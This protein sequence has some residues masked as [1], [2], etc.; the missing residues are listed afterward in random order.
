VTSTSSDYL[1]ALYPGD[2]TSELP[3]RAVELLD[4]AGHVA[5]EYNPTA[6]IILGPVI[7]EHMPRWRFSGGS[8]FV[9]YTVPAHELRR[10]LAEARA[11][12]EP[13]ELYYDRLPGAVGDEAWRR[14]AVAS[15]VSLS[16]DGQGG[17]SSV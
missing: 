1:N 16:E 9:P 10:V 5:V 3:P 17:W 11:T 13:F 8:P 4:G 12:G 14:E 6:R 2:C 7:R 15:S